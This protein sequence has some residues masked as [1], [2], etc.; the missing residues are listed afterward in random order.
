LQ[1]MQQ[2]LLTQPLT[3]PQWAAVLGLSLVMPIVVEVDKFI[4]RAR[5]H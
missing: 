4:Q 5:S 2:W 1:F 3:G